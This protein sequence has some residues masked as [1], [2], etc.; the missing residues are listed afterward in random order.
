MEQ[1]KEGIV[2]STTDKCLDILFVELD[3]CLLFCLSFSYFCITVT[4]NIRQKQ[5]V[6]G[7]IFWLKVPEC[8]IHHGGD[9]V[10]Q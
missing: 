5:V 8:S 10:A 6:G 7:I 1:E 2:L 3:F 4:K 9:T